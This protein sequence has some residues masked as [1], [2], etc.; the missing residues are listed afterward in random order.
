MKTVCSFK[1]D[2]VIGEWRRL[3][4]EDLYDLFYST[5]CNQKNETVRACDT[6]GRWDRCIHNLVG[7]PEGQRP[8]GR[9]KYR[10]EDNIKMY[11]QEMGWRGM[12]G[13]ILLWTR[14]KKYTKKHAH[15]RARTHTH[16]PPPRMR[17]RTYQTLHS[18][19]HKHRLVQLYVDGADILLLLTRHN[20]MRL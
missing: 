13:L 18:P 15:A 10:G 6:Y 2:E 4:D 3:Y 11:I 9:S 12:S 17:A 14:K 1:T 8:L 19:I 5:W 16:T 7:K 20:T